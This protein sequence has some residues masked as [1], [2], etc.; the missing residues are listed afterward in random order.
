MNSVAI[1]NGAMNFDINF[2]PLA[3]N[4]IS[5]KITGEN[6]TKVNGCKDIYLANQMNSNETE[7]SLFLHFFFHAV[8]MNQVVI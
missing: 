2:S 3:N 4:K 6:R 5:E 8:R 7:C 1:K